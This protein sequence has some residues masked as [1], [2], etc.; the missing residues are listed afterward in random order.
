[1]RTST[2]FSKQKIFQI[3]LLLR[4]QFKKLIKVQKLNPIDIWKYLK[5]IVWEKDDKAFKKM[6]PLIQLIH[7]E[8]N[9][10]PA[11]ADLAQ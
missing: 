7:D 11:Y 5:S 10:W 1:M 2:C 6:V 9:E 3:Y 8:F 4:D